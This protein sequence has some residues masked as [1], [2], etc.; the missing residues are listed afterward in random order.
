MPRI[1]QSFDPDNVEWL[2]IADPAYTDYKVDYEYSLL[3]YDLPTGR[4]DMLLR[5]AKGHGYCRRHRHVASTVTLVLEGEQHVKEMQ[6]D[7][8]FK[9]V[10]RKKGDYALADADALPHVEGGGADGGTVILSMTALN[11]ILFEYFD[12]TMENRWTLSIEQFVEAWN[13]RAVFGAAPGLFG[14][15]PDAAAAKAY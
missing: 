9:A 6:P 3:G 13:N 14:A 10:S 12:E 5:Y 11:G 1:S 4:L 7:G 15:T 8:S 2:R